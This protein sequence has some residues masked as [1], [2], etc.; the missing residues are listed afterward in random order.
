MSDDILFDNFIITD[1]KTVADEWAA[2]TWELKRVQELA[3]SSSGV[4]ITS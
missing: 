1:D 4:S 3:G 2:D